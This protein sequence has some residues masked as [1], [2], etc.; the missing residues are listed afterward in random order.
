MSSV[1]CI[2]INDIDTRNPMGN[3]SLKRSLV[4]SLS[5]FLFY[6]S[7]KVNLTLQFSVFLFRVAVPGF[8]GNATAATALPARN[9][10]PWERFGLEMVLSI[11]VILS[12]MINMDTYRKYLGSA[13]LNIGAAYCCC[14]LVMVSTEELEGNISSSFV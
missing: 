11:V 5:S 8:Q 14:T 7:L 1:S 4:L 3:K 10:A 6:L 9:I 12:Y 2:A 13:A